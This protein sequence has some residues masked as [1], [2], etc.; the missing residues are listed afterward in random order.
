MQ[1]SSEYM[2]CNFAVNIC[3]LA[4]KGTFMPKLNLAR[5]TEL[6]FEVR[7]LTQ[8]PIQMHTVCYL[9]TL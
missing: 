2:T 9:S 8:Q 6:A 4:E 7:H 1:V 5:F 3:C